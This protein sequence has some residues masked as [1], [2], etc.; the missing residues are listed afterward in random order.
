MPSYKCLKFGVPKVVVRLRRD[1]LEERR[2]CFGKIG[3]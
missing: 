1:N 2:A 3:Y